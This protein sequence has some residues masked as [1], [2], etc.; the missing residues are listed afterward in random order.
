[1]PI[2]HSIARALPAHSITNE[3]AAERLR[4]TFAA[5]GED[6]SLVEQV[7]RNAGIERRYLARPPGF[8]LAETS[9]TARNQAYSEVAQEVGLAACRE[10]LDLAAVRP[11]EVDLIIDTSCTGVMIPALD[12]YV[13]DALGF[14]RDVRRLPLTEAGCAAGATSLA[15]AHDYLRAHPS[16]VVLCLSTELPSLTLQLG[17]TSRANLVSAAIFGDGAAAVVVS[18]R[19]PRGPA[20]EHLAHRT[21]L[22]PDTTDIMG[23]DLRTEGFK[24]ILSKRIPL[25][26]RKHLRTEVDAFLEA[27]GLRLAEMSFFAVHPGGTKV[28]D[29]VRDVLELREDDVAASRQTLRDYGNLSSASVHF[30]T[31]QL[32]EDKAIEPGRFGLML[33]MGPGFTFELALLRGVS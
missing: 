14:R 3:E 22:F 9:L 29:N 24:I 5:S 21:L 23:F 20:V 13:A 19:R 2:L 33:A 28:L 10:A 4:A 11:D 27:Q 32:L 7:F 12:A 16:A 26:V 1:M 15:F 25:L 31:K 30:V 18:N 17:D 6:P 8:Y